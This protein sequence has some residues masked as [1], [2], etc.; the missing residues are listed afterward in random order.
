V[1]PIVLTRKVLDWASTP[2]RAISDGIC[3]TP[4]ATGEKLK[5]WGSCGEYTVSFTLLATCQLKEAL[6]MIA[7]KQITCRGKERRRA[8]TT[9]P[10]REHFPER[11]LYLRVFPANSNNDLTGIRSSFAICSIVS[12]EGALIPRSIKLRKST[13]ILSCSANC[14]WVRLRSMRMERS[15]CPKSFLS[16]GMR[17]CDLLQVA[18]SSL[19]APP[20]DITGGPGDD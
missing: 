6:W 17:A 16:D 4:S 8:G 2:L 1:T 20:N 9:R 19:R 13:E 7:V 15:R 14:S 18:V 12:N 5:S 3:R 10:S 11:I